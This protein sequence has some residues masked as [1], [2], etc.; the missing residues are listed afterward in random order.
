M[1]DVSWG[2]VPRFA[3]YPE[4]RVARHK[5]ADVLPFLGYMSISLRCL[6]GFSMKTLRAIHGVLFAVQI[7][8]FMELVHHRDACC[9]DRRNAKVRQPTA[10][11]RPPALILSLSTFFFQPAKAQL[12]PRQQLASKPHQPYNSYCRIAAYQLPLQLGSPYALL[13]QQVLTP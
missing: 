5:K 7:C 13:S 8:S 3:P 11:A 1:F 4:L 2:V 10:K 12:Q 6:C 9:S